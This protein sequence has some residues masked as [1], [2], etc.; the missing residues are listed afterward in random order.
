MQVSEKFRL[1]SAFGLVWE[2]RNSL[3]LPLRW[4]WLS[5]VSVGRS[6]QS[7]PKEINPKFI[8]RTNA[9][10]EDS[11]I[12][13]L[14]RGV[15]SLEKILMLGKIKG[16]SR[17]A[18]QRMRWLNRIIDSMDMNLSK[19]REIVKDRGDWHSPVHGTAKSQTW[20]SYGTTIKSPSPLLTHWC[21]SLSVGPI[22]SHLMLEILQDPP[23]FGSWLPKCYFQKS[24]QTFAV[25]M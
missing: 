19:L 4:G 16:R 2:V 24:H 18:W 8:G 6:N 15:N 22:Y 21:Y 7:I 20:L 25:K 1:L 13:H 9:E 23:C 14:I 5:R 17:R 3:E 12:G 10:A 11:I